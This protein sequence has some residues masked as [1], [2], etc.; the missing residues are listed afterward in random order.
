MLKYNVAIPEAVDKLLRTTRE[1]GFGEIFGVEIDPRSK[2]VNTRRFSKNETDLAKFIE[3]GNCYIDVLT[4]HQSEPV[5]AET[6]L[7]EQGF[8][9]SEK[10]EI[11]NRIK[12]RA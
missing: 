10:S 1:L 11:P 12:R 8:P 3:D 6:R 2:V 7:R 9:M 5:T 4:V